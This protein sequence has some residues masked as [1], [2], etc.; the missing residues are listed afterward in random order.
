MRTMLERISRRCIG[1]EHGQALLLTLIL[2]AIGGLTIATSLNFVYT[3]LDSVKISQSHMVE[4]CSADAGLEEAIWSLTRNEIPITPGDEVDI[5]QYLLNSKSIDVNIYNTFES[6]N[7]TFR[8]TSIAS[9]ENRSS[10]TVRSYVECQIGFFHIGLWDEQPGKFVL[11][12]NE[13][14]TGN[15]HLVDGNGLDCGG[16]MTSNIYAEEGNFGFHDGAV[17][18]GDIYLVEGN[19][20]ISS[21]A[22]IYGD[23][24]L[25]KGNITLE[26]AGTLIEGEI[27][28]WGNVKIMHADATVVGDIYSTNILVHGTH[29]GNWTYT[30]NTTYECPM[31]DGVVTTY[32]YEIQ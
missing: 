21:G 7:R 32:S 24:C 1:Q 9:T 16:N 27:H 10:T 12:A 13:T 22:K 18:I 29:T 8:I 28:V 5:A 25:G 23:I 3:S 17:V 15:L 2:L 11:T 31:L 30:D 19:I 26:D 14:Y 6:G 4:L 20:K